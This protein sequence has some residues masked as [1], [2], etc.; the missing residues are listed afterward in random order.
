MKDS[1][2]VKKVVAYIEKHLDEDLPLDRIAKALNYSKYYIARIFQK[3][4]DCTIYKYIQG[5]RLTLAAQK[6]VETKK[7]IV[8]I[9][10]EAHYNS[11]QAFTLAFRQVYLCSPQTY[12]KNGIFYPKQSR[13]SMTG[14]L[15]CYCTKKCLN[16]SGIQKNIYRISSTAEIFHFMNTDYEWGGKR[17][18]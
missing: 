1:I 10:Y 5:R 3:N 11:Q 2:V 6:L 18:S 14:S 17:A 16:D 13:I 15:F 9:A 8:E 12:R 7:P 4:T